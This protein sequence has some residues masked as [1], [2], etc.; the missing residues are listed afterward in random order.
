MAEQLGYDLP[1]HRW[2]KE[3]KTPQR[4]VAF[5]AQPRGSMTPVRRRMAT[6]IVQPDGSLDPDNVGEQPQDVS[7]MLMHLLQ[8]R[9]R[10]DDLKVAIQLLRQLAPSSFATTG[11]DGMPDAYTS[12][13]Q[14]SAAGEQPRSFA[15]DSAGT[16]RQ[17]AAA[18]VQAAADLAN[19]LPEFGRL[20]RVW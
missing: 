6:D 11:D 8:Q 18:A 14:P 7:A 1:M 9:L 10:P 19:E 3:W 4:R 5:D 15:A 16:R 20:R 17:H 2:P 13:F 12:P